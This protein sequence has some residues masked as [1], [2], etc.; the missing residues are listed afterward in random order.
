ML[1]SPGQRK[2]GVVEIRIML[3]DVDPP[4]GRVAVLDRGESR[5]QAPQEVLFTGWLGLLRALSE[6]TGLAGPDAPDG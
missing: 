3:D 5:R 2:L 1:P 6:V 4:V